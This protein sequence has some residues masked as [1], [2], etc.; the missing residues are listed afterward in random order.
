MTEGMKQERPWR[1]KTHEQFI[2]ELRRISP[3][4]EVLGTYALGSQKI[5]VRCTVCG[6]EW[7]PIGESLVAGYGCPECAKARRRYSHDD[8]VAR[9]AELSPGLEVL[10]IYEGSNKRVLMRCN[11]CGHEWTPFANYMIAGHGCPK[12]NIKARG[13]RSKLSQ[14]EFIARV[15]AACPTLKVLGEY[16]GVKAAIKIGC[17]ECG[18]V[19]SP[20]AGNVLQ[21]KGCPY[22]GNRMHEDLTG[23]RFGTL[24]VIGPEASRAG[25]ALWRCRCDCGEERIVQGSHLRSGHTRSCGKWKCQGRQD[26]NF[27]RVPRKYFISPGDRFGRWTAVAKLD[28][29]DDNPWLMRCDCGTER[30][31]PAYTFA[32][33]Q[34][35]SCGCF[36]RELNSET[37]DGKVGRQDGTSVSM[38]TSTSP[39]CRSKTGIRGVYP[40]KGGRYR[41]SL[42]FKG[43]KHYLGEYSTIEQ[44]VYARK[45][46]EEIYYRDYLAN[47]FVPRG[48]GK[49]LREKVRDYLGES[50]ESTVGASLEG[51]S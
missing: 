7:S 4:I 30:I 3:T 36:A 14:E 17:A 27:L 38:I 26:T 12:C 9:V 1:R 23:R 29:G 50:A 24:T 20:P 51:K 15:E 46:A 22:C 34:S 10:G 28:K 11:A 43:T 42:G 33:G 21:Y 5:P 41:A 8:F 37:F 39:T 40:T 44:A 25:I 45:I 18:N 2:E 16:R 31:L 6:H 35:T 48:M 19:W 32:G 47:E 49:K 13:E